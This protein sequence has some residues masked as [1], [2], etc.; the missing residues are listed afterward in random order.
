MSEAFHRFSDLLSLHDKNETL[1][2]GSGGA[3]CMNECAYVPSMVACSRGCLDREQAVL[4]GIHKSQCHQ[5]F[6]CGP[7]VSVE[8]HVCLCPELEGLNCTGVDF[9][10]LYTDVRST[11]LFSAL[12]HSAQLKAP[13][14]CGLLKSPSLQRISSVAT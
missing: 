13:V 6:C 8:D 11:F 4:L 14:S 9:R 5:I 2:H 10:V 1:P 7:L 12:S 3:V